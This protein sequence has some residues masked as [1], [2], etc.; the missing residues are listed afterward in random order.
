MLPNNKSPMGSM[1]KQL[2]PVSRPLEKPK[3][4]ST[5]NLQSAQYVQPKPQIERVYSPNAYLEPQKRVVQP[6][7]PSLTLKLPVG[8]KQVGGTSPRPVAPRMSE[9]PMG[10]LNSKSKLAMEENMATKRSMIQPR[11]GESGGSSPTQPKAKRAPRM[12]E[13]VNNPFSAEN[14]PESN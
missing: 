10:A 13:P 3:V 6:G 14:D 12:S 11:S 4:S 7:S 8:T 1:Q 2:S 9:E 5:A